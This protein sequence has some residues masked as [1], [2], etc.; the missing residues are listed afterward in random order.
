M[1]Q[2]GLAALLAAAALVVAGV[3]LAGTSPA[4][5]RQQATAICKRT[6]AKLKTVK[7][8]ASM[9]GFDHFLKQALPV[10]QGQ[11]GALNRLTPPA[12]LKALHAKALTA[13]LQQ[14]VGIRAA[15]VQ[16]DK[17]ADPQKTY[18]AMNR[19]LSPVSD[20]ETAAW[21]KLRI[22]ACANVGS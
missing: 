22:P 6:T 20:A 13:E 17:G 4:Q 21:K 7:S 18:D 15:I 5:Y 2:A 9:K 3:A 19:K 12:S 11:Y 10:F 16:L 1:K 8:P 14:L